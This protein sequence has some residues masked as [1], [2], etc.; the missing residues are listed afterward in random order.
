MS[1]A[2]ALA[3]VSKIIGVR[4]LFIAAAMLA[5]STPSDAATITYNFKAQISVATANVQDFTLQSVQPFDVLPG[6]LTIDTSLPDLNASSD[7]GQFE[8]TSAP[9]VLSLT[10]GPY[11]AF[12]QETY[13]TSTFGVRIAENGSGLFGSE[14]LL[15]LNGGSFVANGNEVDTFELRLDSDNPS[16]L[17]GTG[18]PTALDFGL[19]NAASTFELIGHDATRPLDGFLLMGSIT[20]FEVAPAAV[21]E[22]GSWV[23]MGGGL[24]TLAALRHRRRQQRRPPT[25]R[26]G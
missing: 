23:L 3:T 20:E 12:P 5:A 4:R 13:S 11:G 7:I 22:P 10:I 21:P 8:A 26:V 9:S 1:I 6:T 25:P 2:P 19:L 14:E 18:L 16:F 15:I 17:N 24:L